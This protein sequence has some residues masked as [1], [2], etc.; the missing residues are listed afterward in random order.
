MTEYPPA[1]VQNHRPVA[2]QQRLER[3][4]VPLGQE[5]SQE[6]RIRQGVCL[7]LK[8]DPVQ[9]LQDSFVWALGMCRPLLDGLP[10]DYWA[11][12][13]DFIQD[14]FGFRP[15]P[16]WLMLSKGDWLGQVD[17]DNLVVTFHPPEPSGR[18]STVPNLA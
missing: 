18:H 6:F 2:T 5:A 3:G 12:D 7:F 17:C 14:F 9:M 4:L 13:R 15:K 1:D 16:G 11:E 8:D 10:T